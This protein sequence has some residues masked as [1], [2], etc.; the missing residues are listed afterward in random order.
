ME[1]TIQPLGQ[2]LQKGFVVIAAKMLVQH[3]A[4][5]QLTQ[6]QK[7]IKNG[8]PFG[9][10]RN[11]NRNTEG[12]SLFACL[13]FK[14]VMKEL[15]A[16]F[17]YMTLAFILLLGS[18]VLKARIIS[19]QKWV[20]LLF[21]LSIAAY[22][23]SELLTPQQLSVESGIL[24]LFRLAVPY[25][26]WL[27]VK[28]VFSDNFK[29]KKGYFWGL[30][31]FVS[32]EFLCVWIT[33]QKNDISDTTIILLEMLS[34]TLSLLFVVGGLWEVARTKAI[35]LVPSRIQYREILTISTALTI[36]LTLLTEL[37]FIQKS[38]PEFLIVLQRFGI[39]ILIAYVLYRHI[40]FKNEFYITILQK[41]DTTIPEAPD[42]DLLNALKNK[43]EAGTWRE[44]GLTIQK[45]A[46]ILQ[47]KEYRLRKTI[48]THLAYRN[49]NEFLNFY[50]V[51]E[52]KKLLSQTGKHELNIQEIAF[53]LGYTSL[54]PFNK[55]F[56][57]NT[58]ITPS[59][60]RKN[61][62]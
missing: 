44:E 11:F 38:V 57:D 28:S 40:E 50:R 35:D 60:W 10:I 32:I 7:R 13:S 1:K 53:Q 43:M 16:I 27:Y 23:I 54:S 55:A 31:G 26:F 25:L 3:L 24:L 34:R 47:V 8:L 37:V 18:L 5:Q 20:T 51:E 62:V 17:I 21:L 30:L 6:L 42:L 45:L 19:Q 29:L 41:T 56:K 33:M 4:G 52:A 59:E 36:G 49:F 12:Y 48:N 2:L 14:T 58:G 61:D 39:L 15:A 46:D 22:L 9:I